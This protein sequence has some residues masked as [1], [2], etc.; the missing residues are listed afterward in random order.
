MRGVAQATGSLHLAFYSAG[1]RALCGQHYLTHTLDALSTLGPTPA[2]V[3]VR[4]RGLPG[5]D[6]GV[7]LSKAAAVL[8][9]AG[10]N[11]TALRIAGCDGS[12]GQQAAVGAFLRQAGVALPGLTALQLEPGFRVDGLTQPAMADRAAGRSEQVALLPSS[13]AGQ[14][15]GQEVAPVLPQLAA[16]H[17]GAPTTID[18]HSLQVYTLASNVQPLT[19]LT[20]LTVPTVL[21]DSLVQCLLART[22]AL[23][24]LSVI[25]VEVEN[26]H[27]EHTWGLG[28]LR[29]QPV[30]GE[31]LASDCVKPEQLARLPRVVGGGG[32]RLRVVCDSV[33]I[34][35]SGVQVCHL[36]I[37]ASY[38]PLHH[39]TWH[40]A[41]ARVACGL[42]NMQCRYAGVSPCPRIHA[43]RQI[44][45]AGSQRPHV[46]SSECAL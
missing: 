34:L 4:L 21:S 3:D 12:E 36:A 14:A 42:R 43:H 46:I 23:Q 6:A 33:M 44:H 17:I 20:H 40:I 5:D 1:N 9:Y 38:A 2:T 37:L 25:G 28:E 30:G 18:G 24:S 29:V 10:A 22:P 27:V 16:L 45:C 35:V 13:A 31:M 41:H 11:I 7:A 32:H 26:V 19:N 8:F 39:C 15:K